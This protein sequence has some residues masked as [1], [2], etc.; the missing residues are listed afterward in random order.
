MQPIK[1]AICSFGMSGSV[2]HAPFLKLNPGFDF[3]AVVERTG[4]RAKEK[5]PEV[6]TYRSVEEMLADESIEL[7]V[8]NTPNVLHFEQTRQSLLAG[9]HVLVE[10]P[11]CVSVKE[12][13]E[14]IALAAEKN[15]KI[16]V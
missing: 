4:N 11:F 9:K 1:T 6:Q 8:V 2:F 12:C 15:K 13:D 7:V 3:T 10:K 14:L 5:Y 16:A